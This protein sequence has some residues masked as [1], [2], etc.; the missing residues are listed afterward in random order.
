MADIGK[1]IL[2][3]INIL[4]FVSNKLN[5]ILHSLKTYRL[6][7]NVHFIQIHSL[8]HVTQNQFLCTSL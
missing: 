6:I 3:A 4:F 5:D 1:F 8:L 2:I 7:D